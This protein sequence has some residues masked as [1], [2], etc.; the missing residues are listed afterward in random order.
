MTLRDMSPHSRG[1]MR[2]D[3]GCFFRPT[4]G[5]GNAGR[6]CTRSLACKIKIAYEL[7][8]TVAPVHPTFPH[9]VGFNKLLRALPGDQGFV[10]TVTGGIGVSGP[11][12]PTSP[13]ARLTP[14]LRRQDH[15]TS[16]SAY[17][18]FVK[19]PSRVHRIP[20]PYVRDDRETPL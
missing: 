20:P 19:A 10:D 1:A 15:T 17:G 12:G 5:V 9:G 6:Q 2:P 16:P 14:T 3:Y 18:A 4:K 13:S 7:V 11:I 8:T